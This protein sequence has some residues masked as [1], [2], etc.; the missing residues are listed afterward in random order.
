MSIIISLSSPLTSAG[1]RSRVLNPDSSSSSVIAPLQI[2]GMEPW[3]SPSSSAAALIPGMEPGSS[4]S[5]VAEIP[6]MD[7]GSSSSDAALI[8]GTSF[9]SF[10]QWQQASSGI[11]LSVSLHYLLF[12][13]RQRR[14]S[15]RVCLS[16]SLH[17]FFTFFT[18]WRQPF[19][20][21]VCPLLCIISFLTLT[22]FKNLK[23]IIML[24]EHTYWTMTLSFS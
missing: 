5:D 20:E 16:V 2:P 19:L 24:I 6:R 10:P 15:S 4:S 18:Q 3:V 23:I 12:L 1:C 21:F 13:I 22:S 11:C 7:P 17:T 9:L 8:S 14:P